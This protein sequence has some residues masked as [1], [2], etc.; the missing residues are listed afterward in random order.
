[1]FSIVHSTNLFSLL[2]VDKNNII[3]LNGSVKMGSD[4]SKGSGSG[5]IDMC[6]QVEFRGYNC[7]SCSV[8]PDM[9]D[10][11]KLVA[12]GEVHI[13]DAEGESKNILCF[14]DLVWGKVPSHSW[15]PGQIYDESLVPSPRCGKKR[16][17]SVLVAFYGDGSYAWL[18]YDQIIPFE[19]HFEEKSNKSKIQTFVVAVEEAVDEL[20]KRA[21]L[22]L[23]CFCQ[24]NF[25]PAR[26]QG[27]YKVDVSGYEPGAIYSSKQIKKCRDGFQPH[28]VFSFVKKL[29][30]S[31]RSLQNFYDIISR[32][33]V[34]AYRKTVFEEND[35]TYD[36]AFDEFEKGDETYDQAFGVKASSSEDP[37]DFSKD[38]NQRKE[39]SKD[40]I[41]G[42]ATRRNKT[43]EGLQIKCSLKMG[44]DKSKNL[45]GFGDLVWGKVPSH[46]WWPGQ[47]YDESL[48]R[49]PL[50]HKKRDGSVLVAFYGDF[51][52]AWLDND[53]IIPFEPHFEEKSNKSK[54]QT[55]IV[56]VEEAID[57]LKKRA[58]L[59]LTCFC[60]GSSQP[61]RIA[62][63]YEVD[64]SG[65]DSGAIY[66][67]KQIKKCRGGFQ[68]H[69]MFSF[70]K[71]LAM[72]PRSLQNVYGI[73]NCAK[74]TA[75]RKAVFEDND[76]TYDEAFD[77]FEK[78]DEIYDQAYGVK[79]SSSEDP[80]D[81]SKDGHQLKGTVGS[82]VDQGDCSK[83]SCKGETKRKRLEESP[84]DDPGRKGKF[85]KD[86][87]FDNLVT[88]SGEEIDGIYC[89]KSGETVKKKKHNKLNDYA[90]P[91]NGGLLSDLLASACDPFSGVELGN[92]TG[93][94]KH[95]EQYQKSCCPDEHEKTNK[96]RTLLKCQDEHMTRK[97][98]LRDLSKKY[99][100]Q[101]LLTPQE[102]DDVEIQSILSVQFEK[103]FTE[104]S[105]RKAEPTM[106]VI[107]FPPQTM[108]PTASEL[109]AKFAYFGPFDESATR[110]LGG[111]ATCQI[112]FMY[113]SNA[114]AA[115][116]YAVESRTLFNFDVNY[117][118]TDFDGSEEFMGESF[119][120]IR[121]FEGEPHHMS[122]QELPL[123]SDTDLKSFPK[124]NSKCGEE[125]V[126]SSIQY[127]HEVASLD[128]TVVA[129]N[130][131]Y[132][133]DE[134]WKSHYQ[135][136]LS[137]INCSDLSLQLAN[138]FQKCNEILGGIEG[139]QD[140]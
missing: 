103:K 31:P 22:G 127:K 27:L 128:E 52:Y 45:L 88:K 70:V 106:L 25:Q 133:M 140:Q 71:K 41:K 121:S 32:A 108:L 8:G 90:A 81:F 82:Q 80:A 131:K 101:K 23:T 58:A 125:T 136:N 120:D 92:A 12:G 91:Q 119:D 66:S 107:K 46:P 74:V 67:S 76:E 29:A 44:S 63:L 15:W 55:F 139:S 18:D 42:I 84:P 95:L 20:K 114:Q 102:G 39:F 112:V 85:Q 30:M 1:M 79:A 4:K 49:S 117:H 50:C 97:E 109:K 135:Q 100:D 78:C 124:E 59:G 104:E 28:G 34:T 10:T 62:G 105:A 36:E 5:S 53:Q 3:N 16:D 69:E 7:K 126:S 2:G 110:I 13:A 77:E 130:A 89:C 60:Q 113:K 118:L 48:I 33:K 99:G 56:A 132:S 123:Q 96:K 19:P 68:P 98:E 24:G 9:Y 137:A 43:V 129:I 14:G 6:S 57:E 73:I 122:F 38:G 65:Y 61:T 26:I 54:I 11:S 37:A 51:E 86:A 134:G 17:G 116:D 93:A 94:F 64:V 47:V 40:G 87:F 35:E 21:V 83:E 75:Y 138:L 111:S 115:H 72:S